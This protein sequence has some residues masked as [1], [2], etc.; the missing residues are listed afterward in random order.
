MPTRTLDTDV[1]VVGAGPAGL[2]AAGS[3]THL[4]IR[5]EVIER[6]ADVGASWRSHY[7]RLHLHTVKE[8]SALPHLPFPS[9]WPKYVP[10]EQV[11]EY[12]AS[13]ADHFGIA[14]RLGEEAAAIER[15]GDRW[16]T[17]CRS[18]LR[19]RSRCVVLATGANQVPNAPVFPG[20]SEYR[21]SVTH[22]CAYRNAAPFSGQRVL[23]VGM[24]NTGAEVALDLA[25]HGVAVAISVRSPVNLVY[26]DVLGRPTQLTSMALSRLPTR[27][28]DAIARMLRDLTVGDLS[29]YGIRTP[30]VSPLRQLREEGRTPVIDIGTVALIKSGAIAVRPG[31]DSFTSDG[32]RFVDGRSERYDAVIM[33]TGFTAGVGQLFPG[34]AL[35]TDGKGLPGQV[36]GEGELQ[37]IYFVGF[38]IRQPGGLLRTIALQ[39]QEVA[40]HIKGLLQE[41]A[42][43]AQ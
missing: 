21:G 35:P 31:M 34:A 28:A 42:A 7:D 19:V 22:S 14:P 43:A 8:H 13:Y 5:P 27:M 32:V 2:A 15:A 10:R 16:R 39:A 40:R 29:R 33:A 1:L 38:D 25:S 11:V 12:L 20:Q 4:G 30:A 36:I 9:H 18:G 6:A 26:R 3:L 24:G 17:S 37:G 23:V 41:T